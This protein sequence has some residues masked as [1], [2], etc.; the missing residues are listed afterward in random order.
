M[1]P[2]PVPV[3]VGDRSPIKTPR[4]DISV[5]TQVAAL[6]SAF[7]SQN[8]NSDDDGDGDDD[9]DS[10]DDGDSDDDGDGG[11]ATTMKMATA[12]IGAMTSAAS[13]LLRTT[14]LAISLSCFTNPSVA[15]FLSQ[16]SDLE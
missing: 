14:P 9:G 16:V 10:G 7:S 1:P 4:P 5:S 11:P 12:T 3:K 6:T 2:P 13:I 15:F 8:L